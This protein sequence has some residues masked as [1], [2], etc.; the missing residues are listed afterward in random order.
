MI[1]IVEKCPGFGK[2]IKEHL[3]DIK[4]YLPCLFYWNVP[5]SPTPP[6]KAER[7][8]VNSLGFLMQLTGTQYLQWS[9]GEGK[10]SKIFFRFRS[11]ECSRIIL[12]N[13]FGKWFF[14]VFKEN[15][16]LH[17][18]Y[19]SIVKCWFNCYQFAIYLGQKVISS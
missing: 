14:P 10:S 16:W 15:I 4:L 6:P 2:N 8:D 11:I 19:Q 17:K 1:V 9:Q 7:G 13:W 12:K 18:Y 3:L 5:K